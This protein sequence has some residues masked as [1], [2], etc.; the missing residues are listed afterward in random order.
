MRVL[1]RPVVAAD[2]RR[3]AKAKGSLG[4]PRLSLGLLRPGGKPK[5]VRFTDLM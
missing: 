5:G 2:A 3:A 4:A 1:L